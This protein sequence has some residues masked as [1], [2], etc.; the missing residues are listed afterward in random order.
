MAVSSSN[1]SGICIGR[2]D[3]TLIEREARDL[4]RDLR[5]LGYLKS[6]IDGRFG[7]STELP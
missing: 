4:Q 1:G 5:K 2:K 7:I 6:G 3:S